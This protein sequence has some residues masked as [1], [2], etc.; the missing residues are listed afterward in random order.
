MEDTKITCDTILTSLQEM[1]EQK[2]VLD[3]SRWLD[4]A[5]SLNM[6]LGNEHDA[7][8]FLQKVITEMKVKFIETGDSVAKAKLKSEATEEH[9]QMKRQEAKIERIEEMIRI[10]KIQAR[11]KQE[12]FKGY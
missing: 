3:A 6:L 10:S 4:A 7:L 9:H 5:Q 1:V 11:M 8:F 12:E 2:K